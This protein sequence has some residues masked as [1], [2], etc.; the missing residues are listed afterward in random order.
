MRP[1]LLLFPLLFPL[2]VACK[3]EKDASDGASC[4]D[5]L[6]PLSLEEISVLGFAPGDLLTLAEGSHAETLRWARGG[7][8]LVEIGLTY[9]DGDARFVD[10]EP[11]YPEDG[12]S[13]AAIWIECPDR[14]EVDVSITFVTEDGAFD[15]LWACP[16]QGEV[17]EMATFRQ[18]LDVDALGGTYDMDQDITEPD[19][20]QR[21]AWVSGRFTAEGTTG[22]VMGQV[23]G[24]EECQDGD[25]CS[26]WAGEV[27]IGSWGSG[28]ETR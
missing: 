20:D 6:T 9:E 2:L 22:E 21:S 12:D 28:G 23:S 14:V 26:A 5:T 19:Y 18:E 17:V 24:E 4:E 10:S 27:P 8:T 3:G 16:L 13:S 1:T 15:E 25:T 11:V 7:E